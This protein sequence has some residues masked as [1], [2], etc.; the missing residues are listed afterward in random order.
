MNC[1]KCNLS[2]AVFEVKFS[3]SILG[4][5]LI[6]YRYGVCCVGLLYMGSVFS[7]VSTKVTES[8]CTIYALCFLYESLINVD[9]TVITSKHSFDR[10]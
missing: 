2:V 7:F 10:I 5:N 1:H 3:L 8:L 4:S 6:H 9:S